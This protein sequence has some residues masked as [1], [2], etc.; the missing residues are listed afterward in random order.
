MAGRER[1][2]VRV[3]VTK[4]ERVLKGRMC[5]GGVDIA[6]AVLGPIDLST[7]VRNVCT[8]RPRLKMKIL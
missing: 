8:H 4:V 6:V 7:R 3:R 5:K 1:V 2:G